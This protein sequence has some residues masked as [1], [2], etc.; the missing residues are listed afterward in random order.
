MLVGALLF[1]AFQLRSLSKAQGVQHTKPANEN[2]QEMG[3]KESQVAI[4]E[5]R[6]Q[7]SVRGMAELN[8]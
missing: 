3:A 6:G 8:A 1:V 7:V 5:L 4:A 2:V